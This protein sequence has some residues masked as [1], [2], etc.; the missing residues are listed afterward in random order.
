MKT[1][2]KSDRKPQRDTKRDGEIQRHRESSRRKGGKQRTQETDSSGDRREKHRE[3][4]KSRGKDSGVNEGGEMRKETDADPR[5]METQTEGHR[6]HTGGRETG[7]Y[8]AR[9]M[10]AGEG[11]RDRRAVTCPGLTPVPAQVEESPGLSWT[12]CR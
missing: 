5:A 8:Q 2:G 4:R 11:A 9:R 7:Q 12:V 10:A 3:G 6:P 1:Q